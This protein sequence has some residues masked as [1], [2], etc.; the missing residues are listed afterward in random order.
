M[1]SISLP[2]D[3]DMVKKKQ[4]R[5]IKNLPA[6]GACKDRQLAGP[7][8]LVHHLGMGTLAWITD[9]HLNFLDE[10]KLQHFIAKLAGRSEDGLLITG[11]IAEAP[12]VIGY[13]EHLDEALPFPVWFVLGNHD[14]YRG[15]I[16]A[17][18]EAVS[19]MSVRATRV[20]YLTASRV[21]SLSP[22]T[23]LVGHDGWADGRCGSFL[24]SSIDMNDYHLIQDLICSSK[25][26]RLKRLMT[27]GDEAAAHLREMVTEALLTH[28]E[29]IVA[30][31]VPPYAG[32]CWYQGQAVCN[33]WTPHF[34]CLAAGWAM[35]EVMADHPNKHL[36][37]LCGHTHSRGIFQ[38][39][40]NIV[41]ET[42]DAV[43]GAPAL[44]PV[45]HYS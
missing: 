5:R 38:A 1:P 37:V 7:L 28:E 11:D 16:G 6:K 4:R 9:P 33:E 20:R 41:V 31:H 25:E 42:G 19:E 39:A 35:N 17:T 27:L 32:A 40:E 18:R 12:S 2:I 14:F 8:K 24:T 22:K 23:A 44:Q 36:R 26:Q 43:Y 21:I 13:L 30:T 15:G 3:H 34:T 45:V 29:V 10:E